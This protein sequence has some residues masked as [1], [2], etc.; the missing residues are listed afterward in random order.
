MTGSFYNASAFL[1]SALFGLYLYVLTIRFI[2]AIARVNYFNP[3]TQIIIKLTQPLVAPLRRVVPN[4]RNVEIATLIWILLFELAKLITLSFLMY[5]SF[6][7]T[8]TFFFTVTETIRLILKT[9]FYAILIQAILSWV[10]QGYT[11]IGQLLMQIT[12][13][14]LY[15]FQRVIPPVGGID[16]SAIPALLV[17]QFLLILIP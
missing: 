4:V 14:I 11:P 10:Q 1:I 13:P 8:D 15:P 5:G 6:L 16:I 9:Y 3:V 2:M 12:Q 7:V 17:L